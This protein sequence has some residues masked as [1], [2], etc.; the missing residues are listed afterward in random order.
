MMKMPK[1]GLILAMLMAGSAAHAAAVQ[2]NLTGHVD[3]GY[4]SSINQGDAAN[5]SFTLDDSASP[6]Y[7]YNYSWGSENYSYSNFY[8]AIGPFSGN[9]GGY[10]LSGNGGTAWAY[11]QD[12]Y[13][14]HYSGAGF[15]NST[16][17]DSLSSNFEVYSSGNSDIDTQD[18]ASSFLGNGNGNGN[19][20]YFYLYAYDYLSGNYN[21]AYGTFDHVSFTSPGASAVPVPAAVWLFGSALMGLLGLTKKKAQFSVVPV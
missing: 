11:S 8:N 10:A 1:S 20:L 2:V 6:D 18:L 21:Y 7:S 12:Y 3:Y 17:T 15:Y 4:G 5:V 13:G 19:G 14:Y 16:Y 9:I